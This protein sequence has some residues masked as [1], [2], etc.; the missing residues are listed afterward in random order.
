MSLL[1]NLDRMFNINDPDH[2]K[3]KEALKRLKKI[4]NRRKVSPRKLF[5]ALVVPEVLE[6]EIKV[7]DSEAQAIEKPVITETTKQ[8]FS[9]LIITNNVYLQDKRTNWTKTGLYENIS[10]RF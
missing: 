9:E 2:E 5:K 4:K 1:K 8:S 7:L 3:H 10:N 6:E